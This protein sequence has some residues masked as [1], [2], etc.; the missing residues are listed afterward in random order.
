MGNAKPGHTS[1]DTQIESN[2]VPSLKIHPRRSLF[3]HDQHIEQF[4]LI[5]LDK[6]SQENSLHSLHTKTLLKQ[7]NNDRCLF[8]DDIDL[9]LSNIDVLKKENKKMI[10]VISGSFAKEILS[11]NKDLPTMNIFC[12]DYN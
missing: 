9:C 3:Q 8:F 7:I 10:V 6:S 4:I 2:I 12:Q 11:K 5:W 1:V